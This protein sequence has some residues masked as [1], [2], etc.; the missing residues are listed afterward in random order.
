[1]KPHCDI[2][3]ITTRSKGDLN[4]GKTCYQGH[5]KIVSTGNQFVFCMSQS[6]R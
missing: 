3:F 2:K 1:M 6:L 5:L 4:E